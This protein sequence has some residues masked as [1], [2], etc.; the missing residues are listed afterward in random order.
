MK[1]VRHAA[2]AT[3]AMAKKSAPERN[4]GWYARTSR[5]TAKRKCTKAVN[6]PAHTHTHRRHTIP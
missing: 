5:Y 2:A 4:D 3:P 1:V 6:I